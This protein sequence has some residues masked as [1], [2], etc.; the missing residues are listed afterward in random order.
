MDPQT[1]S[2]Q[3]AAAWLATI[4]TMIPYTDLA[5]ESQTLL[6]IWPVKK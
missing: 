2:R 1:K 3:V 5:H 4:L 6:A